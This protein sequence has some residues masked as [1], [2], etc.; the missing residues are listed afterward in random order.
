MKDNQ[1]WLVTSHND[2]LFT[3]VLKGTEREPN[4]MMIGL[5]GRGKRHEDSQAP[6]I[7]HTEYKQ[8]EQTQSS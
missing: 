7:I 6:Q 8:P 1:G 3:F 4:D 5:L 2:D